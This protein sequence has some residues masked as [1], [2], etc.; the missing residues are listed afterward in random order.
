MHPALPNGWHAGGEQVELGADTAHATA[1]Q[2][3]QVVRRPV[4]CRALNTARLIDD[5]KLL[6]WRQNDLITTR[7]RFRVR[8]RLVL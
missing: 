2:V 5:E 7:R 1:R 3:P 8:D 4:R 6:M